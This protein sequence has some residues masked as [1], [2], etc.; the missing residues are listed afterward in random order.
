MNVLRTYTH[1]TIQNVLYVII[2]KEVT[3]AHA[4]LG[5]QG[6]ELPVQVMN[7]HT[8]SHLLHFL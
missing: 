7:V 2:Q 1:A 4:S 6:M 8:C 5:I 3:H